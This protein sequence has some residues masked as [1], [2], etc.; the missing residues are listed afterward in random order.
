MFPGRYPLPQPSK[1]SPFFLSGLLSKEP[2]SGEV[3]RRVPPTGLCMK[4]FGSSHFAGLA[5]L[6][7]R[8][9]EPARL[10]RAKQPMLH[11]FDDFPTLYP[12]IPGGS[13]PDSLRGDP[14]LGR[15]SGADRLLL[16]CLRRCRSPC[17]RVKLY[18][19]RRAS[20]A[21]SRAIRA[22]SDTSP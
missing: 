11:P 17:S 9:R 6:V 12:A 2:R 20:R 22:I 15:H 5:E 4:G 16:L 10:E 18:S 21:D 14:H 1:C 3:F 13:M 8:S 7:P 19:H